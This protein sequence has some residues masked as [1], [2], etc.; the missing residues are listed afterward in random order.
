MTC[1]EGKHM[2]AGKSANN[3]SVR[4]AWN[5]V[6]IIALRCGVH[7]KLVS[8]T[9]TCD[10]QQD[11]FFVLCAWSCLDDCG[12]GPCSPGGLSY[13]SLWTIFCFQYV[14]VPCIVFLK[15]RLLILKWLSHVK[16]K[17]SDE[18]PRLTDAFPLLLCF[19]L[20]RLAG[21][22]CS[23]I[24]PLLSRYCLCSIVLFLVSYPCPLRDFICWETQLSFWC[25]RF[26][27]S[28]WSVPFVY[29]KYFEVHQKKYMDKGEKWSKTILDVVIWVYANCL[30][31]WRIVVATLYFE[32]GIDF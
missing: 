14:A 13:L 31:F 9:Y 30:L 3:P 25:F 4:W 8:C 29:F 19:L 15:A 17:S 20:G 21:R 6:K 22:S 32:V 12:K 2:W 28:F 23:A 7:K 18:L 27:H 16:V 24:L 10:D 11:L 5:G 1:F 26:S